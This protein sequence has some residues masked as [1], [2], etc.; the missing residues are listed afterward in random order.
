MAYD[1]FKCFFKAITII[2]FIILINTIDVNAYE[3]DENLAQIYYSNANTEKKIALTFDDGP[4]YKYTEEILDILD[5]YDIKATFFIVG[6]LAERYPE[7]IMR[8]IKEGHEIASHTW[9][10]PK[11]TEISEAALTKEFENTERFLYDLAEY[12]PKLFRPPEGKYNNC[13][14]RIAGELDYEVIL[15]TV[16]TRDWAH[17]PSSQIVTNVIN[18]TKPGSIILCHDFIGIDSPTPDALRAFIPKLLNDGYKF[19][20]VSELIGS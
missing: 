20:T 7:I 18:N 13:I 5:E 15:W 11:L 6:Q 16:D 2:I 1:K 9:S 12:E 10:H 14:L 17:T 3:D 4:H 8:E 19:V